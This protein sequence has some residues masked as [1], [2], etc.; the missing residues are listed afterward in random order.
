MVACLVEQLQQWD[1]I[2]AYSHSII[3]A[4]SPWLETSKTEDSLSAN[5]FIAAEIGSPMLY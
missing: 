1:L 3:V 2:Y 5:V 4:N